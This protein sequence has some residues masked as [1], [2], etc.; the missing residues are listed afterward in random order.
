MK[1]SHLYRLRPIFGG[2]IASK[3]RNN[4]KKKAPIYRK[5]KKKEEKKTSLLN[6]YGQV[7]ASSRSE[8][9]IFYDLHC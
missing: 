6:Q 3:D 2:L 9:K 8:S 7:Y 1:I 4:L 5:R